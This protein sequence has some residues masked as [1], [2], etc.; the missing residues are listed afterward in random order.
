M[1][2]QDDSKDIAKWMETLKLTVDQKKMVQQLKTDMKIPEKVPFDGVQDDLTLFRFLSAK[3]WDYE[4]AKAQYQAMRKY[5]EEEKV[6]EI[7]EWH[8]NNPK[9]VKTIESLF[10]MIVRGFDRTG[11]PIVYDPIG[12]IPAARFA[13]LVTLEES[14][15]YHTW[16][17]EELCKIL[18]EQTRKLGRPVYQV[19]AIVDM[20]GASLDSRHFIP[21]FK[22]MS[23]Q[24]SQNYPELAKIV[25][26][27]NAPWIFPALYSLVK[28]FIDPN[29]R[30]KI[31][32]FG[33]SG[34]TDKLLEF[35]DEDVLNVKYGGKNEEPLP[36][37]E[38]I[39]IA[40]G[41]QML[42]TQNVAARDTFEV[43]K[44]C[45]DKRGGKFSWVFN[46]ESLDIN[47][48]VEWKGIKEKKYSTVQELNRVEKHEGE[49][50]VKTK[51]E[52]KFT[53]DNYF[54]YLTSKDVK[55]SF[56]F[57]SAEILKTNEAIKS[58]K[59]KKAKKAEK[60]ARKAK[61]KAD[62][63]AA[64]EAKRSKSY[65]ERHS[66]SQGLDDQKAIL[67]ARS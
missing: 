37:I 57:V 67:S 2:S 30:E 45:E 21:Y 18:R 15:K 5:R 19:I 53:F 3:K 10:P 49:L 29:T 66:K 65:F 55:Y 6:D 61:K 58:R 39:E 36:E 42:L 54:S 33:N 9:A 38:G 17:M 59:E 28:N 62:K 16:W 56:Q 46:L 26:I 22:D 11:R 64:K 13:K 50:D 35:I 8:K 4:V 34:Y 20:N 63:L 52:L 32:V 1:A 14:H 43:I 24:D 60:E 7:F 25:L 41:G 31:R 44:P 47:F 40:S 48:R 23:T 12:A 27:A 51:G